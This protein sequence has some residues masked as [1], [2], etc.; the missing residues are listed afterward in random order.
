MFGHSSYENEIRLTPHFLCQK[1]HMSLDLVKMHKV[2]NAVGET[3]KNI[4]GD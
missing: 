3:E 1:S 2:G 4:S